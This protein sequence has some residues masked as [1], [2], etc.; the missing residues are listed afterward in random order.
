MSVGR[1]YKI[2][3]ACGSRA[4]GSRVNYFTYQQYNEIA[5]S[6]QNPNSR[7]LGYI[8]IFFYPS[9]N[10]DAATVRDRAKPIIDDLIRQRAPEASNN[11]RLT[12]FINDDAAKKGSVPAITY[13]FRYKEK[14]GKHKAGSLNGGIRTWVYQNVISKIPGDRIN[15]DPPKIG[16]DG[17]V[18]SRN[19]IPMRVNYTL[20]TQTNTETGE[21]ENVPVPENGGLTTPEDANRG[22]GGTTYNPNGGFGTGSSW[23]TWLLIGGGVL[24]LVVLVALFLKK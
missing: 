12:S 19:G 13:E 7:G 24:L 3:R 22:N 21:P 18:V 5:A 2:R 17:G 23:T 10:L 6:I 15:G 9:G 14:S 16:S 8:D 11:Y 4:C 1:I 20:T